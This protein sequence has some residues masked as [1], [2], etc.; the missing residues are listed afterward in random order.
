MVKC[1]NLV[2][3]FMRCEDRGH[4]CNPHPYQ[5][6]EA[7]QHPPKHLCVFPDNPAAPEATY[8]LISTVE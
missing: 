4:L 3:D 1:I 7:F 6:V 2:Y 8:I 5:V